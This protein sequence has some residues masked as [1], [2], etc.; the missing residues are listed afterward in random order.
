MA[1]TSAN[2][3]RHGTALEVVADNS[4]RLLRYK[5]IRPIAGNVA[6]QER[7]T[8][9]RIAGNMLEIALSTGEVVTLNE[10]QLFDSRND[11]TVLENIGLA[12][13]ATGPPSKPLGLIANATLAW[14]DDRIVWIGNHAQLPTEFANATRIDAQ[15]RLVTPGLIDCHAHPVFAGNRAAEFGQRASGADYRDIANSGGGIKATLGPTRAATFDQ[16]VALTARRARDA[17]R[18]GTTTLEAKSGYDLTVEGELRLLEVALAVDA[19]QPTDLMPTLLGAHVVP[20]EY[21]NDRQ[22]FVAEVAERMIPLAVRRGLTTTAD[23]YCDDGAFTLAEAANILRAAR[24]HGMRVRA[25]VG[26]FTDVGG[27]ELVASVGGVSADH[28]EH[29]SPDGI[30]ALAA[31]SVIGVML[32]GACVQLRLPPPPV[33]ELRQAGVPLAVA[34]DTNPGTTNAEPL[35]IQ[36]W[37]ATTHYGMTVDEAW[38][39][40]TR[41]AAQVLGRQDIGVLRPRARADILLWDA[42]IPAEIPYRYGTNLVHQIIKSGTLIER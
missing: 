41:T 13:T 25:H 32:P 3:T 28:L 29:V 38:L 26:Q 21:H 20:P 39:G 17:L 27:A 33:A 12:L 24:K 30:R 15:G 31:H 11:T 14:R 18:T 4:R 36:M 6:V 9:T 8:A 37:L 19:I 2:I 5:D 7:I 23:V 16:L 40:V 10:Q 34:S 22:A 42:E 1:I 35:P